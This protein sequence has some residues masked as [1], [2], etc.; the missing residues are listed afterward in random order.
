MCSMLC[1]CDLE[2]RRGGRRAKGGREEGRKGGG[3]WCS[4]LRGAT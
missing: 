3:G 2:V 1:G 4:M